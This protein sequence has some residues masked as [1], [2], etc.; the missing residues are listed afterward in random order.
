ML[1]HE[2]YFGF[3]GPHDKDFWSRFGHVE[4][5]GYSLDQSWIFLDP[6]RSGV[7]TIVTSDPDL[8]D[9]VMAIKFA[10]ADLVIR[11]SEWPQNP[12]PPI[13][14]L[15][16]ASFCAHLVGLR[17]FTLRTLKRNLLAIGGEI[18]HD[19]KADSGQRAAEGDEAGTQALP[20]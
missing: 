18:I 2:W 4:A 19:A 15:T 7:E 8:I 5:W 10:K 20:S 6:T 17:A 9:D 1:V 11:V 14:V 16:C 13:T 12:R 3:H